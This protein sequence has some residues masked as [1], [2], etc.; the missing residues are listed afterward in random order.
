MTTGYV[1]RAIWPIADEAVPYAELCAEATAD[2]PWLVQTAR[3]FITTEGRFSVAP[4]CDV[5][6]SGRVT[7]SVLVWEAQARPAPRTRY[8]RSA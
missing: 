5:P 2:L 7:G 3:V 1:F 6:G 8:Q 4:A